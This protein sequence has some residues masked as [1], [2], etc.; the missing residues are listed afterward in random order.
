[1]PF[2][3]NRGRQYR[4][5]PAQ[6]QVRTEGDGPVI[7]C[8]FSVFNTPTELWPGCVEQIAPGAFTSSLNRDVRALINHET[9]LV[10][11]RTVAGTLNLREDETGLYGSKT[12]ADGD[13]YDRLTKA[14]AQVSAGSGGVLF[15]PWLHGNRCPFEDPNATGMFFGLKLETT[16]AEMIRAVLEGVCYHLRWM[17][18]S[19]EK[20]LKT[21]DPIRFVGGGARSEVICQILADV[22]GRCIETV[23]NPQ[24]VGSVGAAAVMAVGMGIIPSPESVQAFIPI[25][26]IYEPNEENHAVYNRCYAA[27]RKLYPANRKIYRAALRLGRSD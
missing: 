4:F 24:N 23:E 18:E 2:D 11:G 8:Y 1:M 19:Q 3:R 20:M 27:F 14:A 17:L 16:K 15:T 6:M 22:T 5:I 10:L 26:R 7:A 25:T 9:R 13:P 21:S 12:P